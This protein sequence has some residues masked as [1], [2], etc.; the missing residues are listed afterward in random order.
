[1]HPEQAEEQHEDDQNRP[2]GGPTGQVKA[3][4]MSAFRHRHWPFLFVL[5]GHGPV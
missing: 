5:A 4:K 1:M 2:E 3:V